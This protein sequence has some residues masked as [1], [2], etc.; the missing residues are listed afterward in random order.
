MN[1][2]NDTIQLEN[3]IFT[4]LSVL[5]FLTAGAFV[6]NTSGTAQDTGD[7]IIYETD[8]GKLFYDTDGSGAG[9]SVQFAV[10]AANL[11]LTQNDFLIV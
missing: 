8:T 7:R 4:G 11:A 1:V 5:G 9:K 6:K 2:V 10:L 3:A